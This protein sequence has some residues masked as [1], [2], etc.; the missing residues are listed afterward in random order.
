MR[1]S[2]QNREFSLI[3]VDVGGAEPHEWDR[4]PYRAGTLVYERKNELCKGW[5]SFSFFR[6]IKTI[7][8]QGRM[9]KKKMRRF[10]LHIFI[11]NI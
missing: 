1:M 2:L 3:I 4:V 7:S 11:D 10:L 6:S 8:E 9:V 5:R